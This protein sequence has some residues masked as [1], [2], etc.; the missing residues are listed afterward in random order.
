MTDSNNLGPP[1]LSV[2]QLLCLSLSTEEVQQEGWC[3]LES[4]WLAHPLDLK[5]LCR[6]QSTLE[7]HLRS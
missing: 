1:H 6:P 3:L 7:V 2:P 5:L 4:I